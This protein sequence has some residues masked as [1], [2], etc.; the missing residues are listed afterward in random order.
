MAV[1]PDPAPDCGSCAARDERIAAQ[2][3]LIGELRGALGEQ[4][5][6]IAALR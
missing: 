6:Q 1:L 3:E 2:D 4:A 5:D